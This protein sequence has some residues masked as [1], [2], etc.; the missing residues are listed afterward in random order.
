MECF[1]R[2]QFW[3][4]VRNCK[5]GLIRGILKCLLPCVRQRSRSPS[6]ES[7]SSSKDI[8]KETIHG[9]T[10][11]Q[12]EALIQAERRQELIDIRQMTR[13]EETSSAQFCCISLEEGEQGHR[14]E[15]RGF[16]LEDFKIIKC[17]DKGGFGQV[18]LAKKKSAGGHS[19]SEEVCALKLVPNELVSVVEREVLVRAVGHPFLVQLLA[20]FETRQSFCYV[21]EYCK[22]GTL[23]S[24]LSRLERLHEDLARFYAAEIILAVN[25]LHKCGI[26]HRDI[27]PHNILLD[28]DGHCKLAD[29][30]LSQVGIFKGMRT[31]RVCGT[32]AYRAPEIQRGRQYGP[33]VDWWSVGCVLFDMMTGNCRAEDLL[34]PKEHPLYL[35]E[36][37]V[38][39]LNMFLGTDPRRRLGARGDTRS[40]LMHPFFKTVNWEAVLQ[41]RVTPPVEPLTVKCPAMDSGAS[42]DAEESRS[43]TSFETANEGPLLEGPA[44]KPQTVE[45]QTMDAE[46]PGDAD[47]S[48]NDSSHKSANE[49]A[50]LEGEHI[51][52]K[53]TE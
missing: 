32:A 41:K 35:T 31:E 16:C 24:L 44:H 8:C 52:H 21:M 25:F 4:R 28:S 37:A 53:A 38:S 48:Q 10:G 13:E 43:D 5:T 33:E 39:V 19:F 29:F 36:D 3:K 17:L 20:Y 15:E 11:A 18:V 49:G 1:E 23:H 45:C 27:K 51:S 42:G 2:L 9:R 30:G 6:P 47:G 12:Y 40:I 7:N 26:I 34:H 50:V 14:R 22:G 46:A